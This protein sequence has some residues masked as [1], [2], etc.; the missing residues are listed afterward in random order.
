MSDHLPYFYSIKMKV[1]H[2][3]KSR[4]HKY[5][6]KYDGKSLKNLYN[7]LNA[8]DII[9]FLNH[10]MHTDPNINYNIFENILI[11]AFNKN[12]PLRKVKFDKHKHK[13]SKW[14]T[15][16]IIKSITFRDNLYKRMK[17]T[18]PNSI[19]YANHK[20]NLS[21]YNKILR[22]LIKHAKISY[23][24]N[25]FKKYYGNSRQ[26]WNVINDVINRPKSGS[27]PEFIYINNENVSDSGLIANHFNNY[28]GRVGSDMAATV[29]VPD[30]CTH[31]DYL[32]KDILSTFNFEPITENK[33]KNIIV[34]LKSKPSAGYDG[35]SSSLLKYLEPILSGPLSLIINQSLHTGIFPDKL[36]LAKIFPVDK[37]DD[38]HMMQNYRPIS[39][40]P[41]IS[42]IFEKV[43]Y[44]QI[45]TYFLQNNLFSKS[46]YGFR[47]QH[48]TEHAILELV[49]KISL[50][51]DNGNTPIAFYLDLS[52][53]FD[54]L[55][56]NFL[57]SKLK[58]YGLTDLS[59]KWFCNYLS[60]RSQYTEINQIK[61]ATIPISIGVPQGSILGPL[62][63]IIYINDIQNL[64]KF[65]I[66]LN[67]LMI[68]L[69][70]TQC[71]NKI[72]MMAQLSIMN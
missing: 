7:D 34:Q 29:P 32:P 14:V 20:Y 22:Q 48:S 46:Q 72:H 13:K 50:A 33:V 39:I 63:F 49:D 71:Q 43:V 17:P 66:L 23:Y 53:A 26:T 64:S 31:Q 37:K 21:V 11:T 41:T 27:F 19:E 67:M 28:F 51:L 68:V 45:Q 58:T 10:D 25:Q 57:L 62:L 38:I 42:K 4:R 69:Y 6:R 35:I 70:L 30:N 8:T 1:N 59:L 24:N 16:G 5:Y 52:K 12:I 9:S 18:D 15:N 61:S 65:S 55:D 2:P 47:S 44:E 54:T 40:L 3:P 56:H 60:F 36:K